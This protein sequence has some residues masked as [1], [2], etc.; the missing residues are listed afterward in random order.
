[1]N[2]GLNLGVP[3]MTGLRAESSRAALSSGS[4]SSASQADTIRKNAQEFENILVRQML[5]ELR[6][7]PFAPEAD[8][9]K[10]AYLDMADEQLASHISAS[11]GLGFGKA[12][13]EMML[14]QI[15]LSGLINSSAS[16][17]NPST[18]QP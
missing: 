11:G 8:S 2:D 5:R 18:T 12:M 7:S 1:M 14:K 9:M 16:S 3:S 17:V 10:K 13:A 4:V 6:Q 15:K